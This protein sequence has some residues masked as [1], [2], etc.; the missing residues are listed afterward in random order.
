MQPNIQ[1]PESRLGSVEEMIKMGRMPL[2][3]IADM[4]LKEGQRHVADVKGSL[5]N[6]RG[7]L[8][9]PDE[10]AFSDD[11]W[12]LEKKL[13]S[14]HTDLRKEVGEIM[15][16]GISPI[17]V[18]SMLE[19]TMRQADGPAVAKEQKTESNPLFDP[20]LGSLE[21]ADRIGTIMSEI[22]E[23]DRVAF[24]TLDQVA[25]LASQD[26]LVREKTS[27]A[28]IGRVGEKYAKRILS[29]REYRETLNKL[30][31]TLSRRLEG[32]ESPQFCKETN[33]ENLV[34]I[35]EILGD[36]AESVTRTLDLR[37][38]GRG[39]DTSLKLTKTKDGK[40]SD[41]IKVFGTTFD[42]E[43][44]LVDAQIEV[45]FAFDGVGPD[46]EPNNEDARIHRL[47]MRQTK[48]MP[49]GNQK[50][51]LIVRHEIF[52]LPNSIK[53]GGLA[54]EVTRSSL[55]EY[56]ELGVDAITLSANIDVG[57]YA[58]AS[59]GYGWDTEK[60][61]LKKTSGE[62]L[63]AD[64]ETI[65]AGIQTFIDTLDDVEGTISETEKQSIIDDLEKIDRNPLAC[66][67][68]FLA[69]I[70]KKGPFLQQGESGKWYT[71]E[72]FQ[73]A[74]KDGR[75]HEESKKYK[76]SMH[77]GKFGMLKS[78]WQGRIDLKP[79]GPQGGKNRKLLEEKISRSTK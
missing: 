22:I 29:D 35:N 59:Y 1:S 11:F 54:A 24:D 56:D 30:Q 41:L 50:S 70:G 40:F 43:G 65:A 72:A 14:A 53:G 44:N 69:G 26:E 7:D 37:S 73:Q 8:K 60:Y 28:L 15:E 75:E 31:E 16:G 23:K 63:K 3:D 77:A 13:D 17:D 9:G 32:N 45:G 58:W 79:D 48:K 51:E 38:Y 76:G 6:I 12:N 78:H 47:F 68:Q 34:V 10:D 61:K 27:N 74:L 5:N 46:G 49:D 71:G 42:D 39:L 55:A 67:P 2:P 36:R 66:T 21:M 19:E 33:L 62:W 52:D 4:M 25:D 18:G 57:G 20:N 64:I